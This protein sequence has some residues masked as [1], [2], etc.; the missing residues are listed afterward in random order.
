MKR[1][2][3][4]LVFAGLI[5]AGG[6]TQEESGGPGVRT[7][8]EQNRVM[9]PTDTFKVDVPNMTQTLKQ[10]E[11]KTVEIKINRE[12]NFD[13]NVT[14]SFTD[15]PQGVSIDPS[16]AIVAAGDTGVTATVKA[17]PDAAL[18]EFDVIVKGTPATGAVAQSEMKLKIEK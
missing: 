10:G 13:E 14:L 5:A 6:C 7:A 8:D 4:A 1:S 15:L 3:F 2:L 12:K 16:Q 18:G 11:T 17:E 9:P